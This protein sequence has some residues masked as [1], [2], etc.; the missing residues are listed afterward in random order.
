M[1]KETRAKN[2]LKAIEKFALEL[3][4]A[5]EKNN[6]KLI[7]V[8]LKKLK[9]QNKKLYWYSKI[10]KDQKLKEKTSYL[11]AEIK[12]INENKE[13]PK[14]CIPYIGLIVKLT[15][16]EESEEIW[17]TK[18]D[19]IKN[20]EVPSKNDLFLGKIGEKKYIIKKFKIRDERKK[21][22]LENTQCE[23]LCYDNLNWPCMIPV[24]ELSI[25]KKFLITEYK[26]LKNLN[27][28]INSINMV[29]KFFK[30]YI[31]K[32]N[33]DFL[34]SRDYDVYLK[35]IYK[36]AKIL[37]KNGIIKDWKKIKKIFKAYK[38]KLKKNSKFFSHGDFRVG[39]ILLEGEKLI[40]ID[41]EQARKDNLLYDL[42]CYYMDLKKK[43]L[44]K[45][46]Y[47]IISKFPY[48]DEKIFKLMLI[49]RNVEYLYG[50][51]QNES[52]NITKFYS[53]LLESHHKLMEDK[54]LH[55]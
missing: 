13:D 48:F 24:K 12:K 1:E 17:T 33:A 37:E 18:F 40:L 41:F 9:R 39:N 44:Q 49:R 31:A 2:M 50:W 5:L 23:I 3:K 8:L 34:P 52:L 21:N 47:D 46:A 42:A 43:K 35:T 32:N 16:K 29:L 10:K 51:H 19:S 14:K 38:R 27:K 30:Q 20:Y 45:Y 6:S 54:L 7:K 15:I 4:I 11:Q 25:E 55:N 22:D 36:R 26:N 53:Y 28:S